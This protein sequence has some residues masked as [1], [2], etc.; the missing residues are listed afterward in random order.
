MGFGVTTWFLLIV[1][2]KRSQTIRFL[3][4]IQTLIGIGIIG[5]LDWW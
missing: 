1:A 3:L 4:V 2:A 5:M